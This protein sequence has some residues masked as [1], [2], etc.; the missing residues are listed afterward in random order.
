MADSDGRLPLQFVT[1]SGWNFEEGVRVII[2]SV[3]CQ[4]W[5][6]D[7]DSG[8]KDSSGSTAKERAASITQGYVI[9]KIIAII[10]NPD[11]NRCLLHPCQMPGWQSCL[12]L[13]ELFRVLNI[14]GVRVG[15]WRQQQVRVSRQC[16][17]QQVISKVAC[18][19]WK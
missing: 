18:S 19:M 7:Q 3:Q 1:E 16:W 5:L 13:C 15:D 11:C 6:G 17:Q 4:P 14:V 2:E 12:L 9:T 8:W 10:C